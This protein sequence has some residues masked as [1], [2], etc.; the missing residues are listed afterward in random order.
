MPPRPAP[1]EIDADAAP[2]APRSVVIFGGTFDPP[3]RA[4]TALPA[5]VLEG[6]PADLLLYVPAGRSPFKLEHEQSAPHHRLAMLGIALRDLEH[7]AIDTGEIDAGDDAPSYTID[8]VQR[9]RKKYGRDTGL[10]LLLG[11]DQLLS[12]A[13]WRDA[14]QLA[15]LA[16]LAVMVR[17][18]QTHR[19]IRRW[20]R[21]EAP[22]Y[23]HEVELIDAP[24]MDVSSSAIR[25]AVR[26]GQEVSRWLDPQVTAYIAQHGLY[27]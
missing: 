17:P 2:A 3:H 26:N 9:L 4:H 18:P 19:D 14:E 12:F 15:K 11:T 1:S 25:Q 23:L 5:V 8:T 6:L 7:T 16:P 24:V 22:T 21:E 20:L 13:L 27:R 10:R